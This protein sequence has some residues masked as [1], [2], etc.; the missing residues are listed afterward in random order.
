MLADCEHDMGLSSQDMKDLQDGWASMMNRTQAKVLELGGFDWRMFRPGAGT[1]DGPPF[2][3]LPKT[4]PGSCDAYM[5]ESCQP[6]SALQSSA[7]M[8]G[9]GEGCNLAVD[10]NGD[11]TDLDFHLP[12]FL[13]LRGPYAWLGNSEEHSRT[14]R[15][16]AMFLL[17]T[18]F[19]AIAD[20]L[21]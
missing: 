12:A 7:M 20:C 9:L 2:R 4:G 1:C 21:V 17:D 14:W 18:I 11:P 16:Y 15:A 10:K 19:N 13:A 8:Y 3:K 5:R 6:G